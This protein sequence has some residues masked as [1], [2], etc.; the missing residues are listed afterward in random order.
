MSTSTRGLNPVTG[1][2]GQQFQKGNQLAKGKGRPPGI[3]SKKDQL[4]E[5]AIEEGAL[6]GLMPLQFL[7]EVM[8]DPSK[9][10]GI[11]LECAKV[12]AP[13]VHKR[14]PIAV[15]TTDVPF[16]VFDINELEGLS[17]EELDVLEKIMLKAAQR[18]MVESNRE[19]KTQ[20]KL[21]DVIEHEPSVVRPAPVPQ[22]SHETAV[23]AEFVPAQGKKTV[24][25]PWEA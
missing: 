14:Q 1:V 18:D 16:K 3:K 10:L 21:S 12:A 4:L 22:I 13:Y 5:G 25:P 6:T 19:L 24:R 20:Q 17:D 9:G 23:D 11:R 8:R 2:R 15:E 7:L